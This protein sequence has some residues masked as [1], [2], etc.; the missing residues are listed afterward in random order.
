MASK[1]VHFEGLNETQEEFKAIFEATPSPLVI[2]RK[3]DGHI[4]YANHHFGTAFG[5]TTEKLLGR[6]APDLYYNKED[7]KKLLDTLTKSGGVENYEVRVK[8]LDGK[9]FWVNASVQPLVFKNE[10]ALFAIFTNIT[11]RKQAEN[12]A[13][14]L[15]RRNELILKS[16]GQGIYGLDQNGNTTFVNPA[17]AKMLGWEADELLGQII[18]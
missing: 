17:A 3:S 16:A 11:E 12:V 15:R 7:R 13:E 1:N 4:L 14:Q 18:P 6:K 5:V 8:K 10:Q 9:P 2:T